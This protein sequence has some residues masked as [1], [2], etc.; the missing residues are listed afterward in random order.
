M[1]KKELLTVP[2]HKNDEIFTFVK[3]RFNVTD[4]LKRMSLGEIRYKEQ[5]APITEWAEKVLILDRGKPDARPMSFFM[6]I[7]YSHLQK[8]DNDR[9]EVP[10][11]MAVTKMGAIIVDGNHRVAKA[12][13]QGIDSLPCRVI[14]ETT[15][16]KL[17]RQYR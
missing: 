7:D 3:Y 12:Y 17:L 11:V 8:I 5:S 10:I 9:L 13:L 4:M 14:C 15:T 2:T 16:T 1:K 6:R